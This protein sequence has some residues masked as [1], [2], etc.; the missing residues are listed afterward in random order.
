MTAYFITVTIIKIE[1]VK[2]AR[3]WSEVA[4]HKNAMFR[5]NNEKRSQ[6]LLANYEFG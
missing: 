6:M 2:D 3:K 1:G 5:P 4:R